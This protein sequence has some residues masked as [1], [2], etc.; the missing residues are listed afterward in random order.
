MSIIAPLSGNIPT[1][2][3]YISNVSASSFAANEVF[4]LNFLSTALIDEQETGQI[5]YR[6]KFNGSLLFGTNDKVIDV[7]GAE[8]NRRDD[9][10][11]FWGIEQATPCATL[12]LTIVK[13]L[14]GVI[15][16]YWE[17]IFSISDGIFDI[18]RCT[19]E[20]SPQ[21]NDDYREILEAAE[22]Q[23][24][25][26]SITTD[27]T[28]TAQLSIIN[29]G[30]DIDYT[31]NKWLARLGSDSVLE[32]L[33]DYVLPGVTVS[34]DFFTAV[35]NPATL[36]P[37]KLLYLTIAQKS[38]IK[39]PDASYPAT[40]GMMS[41]NDL[42]DIMWNMFQVL[43]DYDADT[44]TIN[45]EHISW[46][47]TAAGMDLRTQLASQKSN[48][49]SYLKE[50][51]PKYER[52]KMMEQ[53]NIDF[54]GVDIWYDSACSN[55]DPENNVKEFNVNNVTTDLEYIISQTDAVSD[56]GF[57]IL[58]NYEDT[59]LYYVALDGGEYFFQAL[60]N[61]H[62]S[63]ATLHHNYFRHNR[64]LSSGYL[65]NIAIDFWTAQKNKS[66]TCKAILCDDYDPK[67]SITTEL[68]DTYLGG[69]VAK[70]RHASLKPTGEVEFNLVY[71][72]EGNVNTGVEIKKFIRIEQ[73]DNMLYA[74]CS[75]VPG[76]D[77]H[78]TIENT[79]CDDTPQADIDWVVNSGNR[80]EWYDI[81]G[82]KIL[83]IT[84]PTAGWYL[85]FIEDPDYV[86]A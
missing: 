55:P 64:V 2:R 63:W 10:D 16:I 11:F 83:L 58:C 31:N 86:C 60:L 6:R 20:V 71:G 46:W 69:V 51:M 43:W 76:V 70:V 39:R 54:V 9:F 45:V 50:L 40:V 84:V 15:D 37:N 4:P 81:T 25:I 79:L 18:D 73:V 77:I 74:C 12:Y 34:S 14:S 65:N 53:S 33:A 67:D 32:Y 22:D 27:V 3:F 17:G 47:P 41:W 28:T 36:N 57:V 26:L 82:L 23:Y 66:Q 38:D 13:S 29:G 62:L 49:Y 44:D 80:S 21:P 72:P 61:G 48:K 35:N 78:V 30:A 8:Q 52:F 56:D 68:G 1:Y 59:G 19:Y 42:M 5:F 24:N 85:Y 75:E 7:L